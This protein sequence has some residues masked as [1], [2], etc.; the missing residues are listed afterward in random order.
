MLKSMDKGNPVVDIGCP[1]MYTRAYITLEMFRIETLGNL[2]HGRAC[3][4]GF[5]RSNGV[6]PL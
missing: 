1:E 5:K 6:L 2:D 3:R 4:V